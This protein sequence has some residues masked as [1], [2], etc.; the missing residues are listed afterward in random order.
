MQQKFEAISREDRDREDIVDALEKLGNSSSAG[1][2]GVPSILLKKCK[3]SLADPL[4]ILFSNF[5]ST[6]SIPSIL[7]EA[8]VIPIHKGGIRSDPGN[9]RPVSLTSHIIKTMERIIRKYLVTHLEFYQKLNPSQHGFRNQRSCLSQLL[10]HQ[11]KIISFLEEGNNVDSVYLDFSKAFDKVDIGILCHKL[12]S[13]GVGGKLGVWLH[14]FL[15]DRKQFIIANGTKSSKSEVKSGVPQGTDTHITHVCSK[16][17]QKCG[18]ILRTFN[19]RNTNFMKF[20]WK[21]LV[22]GHI[23]YCSQLY[24]P[25]QTNQLEKIEELMKSFTKK[26]PQVKDLDYWSRLKHLKMYSQ[27]RRAERYKIM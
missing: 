10:E 1:P 9:F 14:S 21:S 15:S 5:L 27:Q 17:R 11:D 2:D 4:R 20:M 26:I 25:N 6:G 22:Q 13:L 16:V 8:F 23:D 18:W 3:R 7:K 24:F 19:C 12:R